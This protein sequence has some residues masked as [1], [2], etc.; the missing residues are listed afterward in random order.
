[1]LAGPL[2]SRTTLEGV[3][4]TETPDTSMLS[5]MTQHLRD[6]APTSDHSVE[7]NHLFVFAIIVEGQV[8]QAHI[9]VLDKHGFV[10][11]QRLYAPAFPGRLDHAPLLLPIQA[12]HEVILGKEESVLRVTWGADLLP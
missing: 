5:L 3:P 11:N 9:Q 4:S 1:M 8:P 7:G 10:L 2:R 12:L 6:P